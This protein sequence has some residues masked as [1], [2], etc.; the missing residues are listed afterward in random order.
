MADRR[1][2]VGL[3][4]LALLI[5]SLGA[6]IVLASLKSDRQV[7]ER[8]RQALL[9]SL[10][11]HAAVMERALATSD[12]EEVT[13]NALAR[14]AIEQVHERY[15]RR[16][17]DG[18]GFEFVYIVD[19][20][21]KVLYASERG[22]LGEVRD[23]SWIRPAIDRALADGKAGLQSG[24]VSGGPGTGLMVARP[25]SERSPKLDAAQPLVAVT[26]D[27]VDPDFLKEVAEPA[28][29]DEVR[30]VPTSTSHPGGRAVFVPNLSDGS[31]AK[32]E[33]QGSTP[34]HSLLQD[35]L[36]VVTGF[37]LLLAGVFLALMVRAQSMAN[38]LMRSEA[39]VRE[40]AHQDFLTG[41]A[42]RGYFL[43]E[44]DAALAAR[45]EGEGLALLFIDLDGFKEINDG[46]GHGA[47]DILLCAVAAKLREAVDM[48]GAIG[49]FGGDEF[50]VFA[51]LD[52]VEELDG[53]VAR[54]FQLLDIPVSLETEPVRVSASIGAARAPQDATTG[55]ELMRLADIALY[56][57][58]AEGR[59]TFRLFEMRFEHEQ[60]QRRQIVSELAT[61]IERNELVLTFQPQVSLASERIVGFEV[62]V[63]W[64]HPTRGR[65]MP[66]DFVGA[67]EE[68]PLITALDLH[69]LRRACIE[70]RPL[71]NRRLA[72]NVS[73]MTL[74]T[75]GIARRILDT[76]RETGFDPALL[77]VEITESAVL[78]SSPEIQQVFDELREAGVGLAL[79]DFGTGYAS[80]VHVRRF[81][82]TKIKIDKAFIFKLGE[83]PDAEAI[84]EYKV[85]VGRSLGLAVTAE[86]VETPDQLRFL[87]SIGMPEAQGYLF[88]PPLPL[89]AAIAMLEREA[90]EGGQGASALAPPGRSAASLPA[91]H[92]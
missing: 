48:P 27:V 34:G 43:D 59:G 16:L 3:V 40:L 47:G 24:F 45:R 64:D 92:A 86:G 78:H 41:L 82:I 75:I 35:L 81:P 87:R 53:L 22:K 11:S 30:L 37:A 32:L 33:W 49:R 63:R 20:N 15:G 28:S 23:L 66:S 13:L 89:A 39:R 21:G 46:A 9:A 29:L 5:A 69:I 85:R 83:D 54:I 60:A 76:L 88:A 38:A 26:V 73:P 42:N 18:F 77:E 12:Q 14:G 80:V 55:A 17:N 4:V 61:A 10:R 84:V 71:G 19:A 56:R 58:K 25:F 2:L 31:Q 51:R 7:I 57:A 68:S 65:L 62:L 50:V 36:P 1:L 8:E 52:T 44:L 72:V 79:D 90:E 70:A 74:R 67:A 6:I 91:G